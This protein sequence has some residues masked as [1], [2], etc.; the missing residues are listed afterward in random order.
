MGPQADPKN[1]V[2][3]LTIVDQD[4]FKNGNTKAFNTRRQQ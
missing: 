3:N 1:G 2:S 4:N